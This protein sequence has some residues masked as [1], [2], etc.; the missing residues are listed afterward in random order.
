VRAL[1]L[2]VSVQLTFA[3]LIMIVDLGDRWK[4]DLD[5]FTVRA[6]NFHARSREG[7][8]GFHAAHDT[9]HPFSIY[10]YY[11]DVVFAIQWLQGSKCFGNFHRGETPRKICVMGILHWEAAEVQWAVPRV[12]FYLAFFSSRRATFSGFMQITRR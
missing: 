9:T 10:S 8:S 2:D 6:F 11:L 1:S 4:R 5:D 3:P 7:L 12:V